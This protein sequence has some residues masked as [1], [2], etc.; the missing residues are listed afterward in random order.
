MAQSHALFRQ[1]LSEI[2]NPEHPLVKLANV[3][4][5]QEIERSLWCLFPDQRFSPDSWQAFGKS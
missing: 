5:G 1:P 2:L 4:D 3:F